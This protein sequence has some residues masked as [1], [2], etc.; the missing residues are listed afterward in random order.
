MMGCH[1]SS[2]NG[3]TGKTLPWSHWRKVQMED[4]MEWGGEAEAAE[5]TGQSTLWHLWNYPAHLL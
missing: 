1:S 4:E 3:I 5:L 2:G